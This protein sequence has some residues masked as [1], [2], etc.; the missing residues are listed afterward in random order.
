MSGRPKGIRPTAKERGSG[1]GR[2]GFC[3]VCAHEG[4]KFLNAAII[5]AEA[6]KP[7]TAAE[8]LA[9]MRVL[10]PE[11]NYDRHGFYKHKQD[12]LTSPLV[13]AV[14]K[15]KREG[16]LILPKNNAEALEMVRDLGMKTA[17]D[18]PESIGVDH[19]LRAISEMEKK[20]TGPDNFWV[21]L[22][23]AQNGEAP[24]LIVGEFKE[25]PQLETAQEAEVS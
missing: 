10:D 21:M 9:Y 24:E 20:K 22:S 14:E 18:N 1:Y 2:L 7:M 13:T 25:V 19:A 16:Q 15:T 11:F 23:R 5:R 8:M 3:K 12:H 17:I 6:T 4:A